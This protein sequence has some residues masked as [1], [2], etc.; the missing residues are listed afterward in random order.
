MATVTPL[1]PRRG[2][3]H[4]SGGLLLIDGGAGNPLHHLS[5]LNRM[6]DHRKAQLPEAARNF[7]ERSRRPDGG[8]DAA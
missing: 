4:T 3:R 5:G 2:I 7:G 8:G 1:E 6:K